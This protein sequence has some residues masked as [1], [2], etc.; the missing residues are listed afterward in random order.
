MLWRL[1]LRL[2]RL[3]NR[4]NYRAGTTLIFWVHIKSHLSFVFFIRVIERWW[5]IINL[6]LFVYSMV[7]NFLK[8]WWL[9]NHLL[10]L[11]LVFIF[12]SFN[13]VLFND[14]HLIFLLAHHWVSLSWI[15]NATKIIFIFQ[16][17]ICYSW[18]Q[19]FCVHYHLIEDSCSCSIL[20]DPVGNR[21]ISILMAM[22]IMSLRTKIRIV[23]TTWIL[24]VLLIFNIASTTFHGSILRVL[25]LEVYVRIIVIVH[26][27]FKI[28][29]NNF[30]QIQLISKP[31]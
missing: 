29:K 1:T 12:C 14:L 8:F 17:L 11:E 2:L 4:N 13:I 7:L 19:C 30:L 26:Y 27:N 9:D 31:L 23:I 22:W 10:L 21:I 3:S 6:V 5:R 28:M 15:V 16:K 18:G 20:I 25:L 24:W